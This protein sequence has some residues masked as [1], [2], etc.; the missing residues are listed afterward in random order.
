MGIKDN[1]E[2]VDEVCPHCNQVTK[3]QRGITKQNMKRLFSFKITSNEVV[4][5][6]MLILVILLA[7]AYKTE[8]QQCRDWIRPM[9]ETG[10]KS[11]DMIC[12][13]VREDIA[14][15]NQSQLG[16]NLTNSTII[17]QPI[18]NERQ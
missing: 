12:S 7:Y 9:F 2:K 8:T 4:T 15:M 10:G 13:Q 1:W 11:C 18:L 17:N 16:L 5:T 3:R 6:I 14:K